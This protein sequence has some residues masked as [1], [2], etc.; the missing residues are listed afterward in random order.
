M[1]TKIA[2][3]YLTAYNPTINLLTT[4]ICNLPLII[5][6]KKISKIDSLTE[7]VIEISRREWESFETSW[8]FQHHPLLCDTSRITFSFAKWYKLTEDQ[9]NKLKVNY[10]SHH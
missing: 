2:Y 7:E 4:D 1:N 8:N 10:H 6:E 5:E 9:F 3:E